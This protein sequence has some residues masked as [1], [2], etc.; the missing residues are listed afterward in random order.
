MRIE[1]IYKNQNENLAFNSSERQEW[2]LGLSNEQWRRTQQWR[3]MASFHSTIY[4]Q[5]RDSSYFFASHEF[6]SS[7]SSIF[8]LN[9][10]LTES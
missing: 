8:Q 5:N 6:D 9:G 3:R 4:T 10:E 7:D 2:L 1:L